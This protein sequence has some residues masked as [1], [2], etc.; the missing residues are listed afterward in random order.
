MLLLG[1]SAKTYQK[2]E[3]EVFTALL[4][5][6]TPGFVLDTYFATPPTY[7]PFPQTTQILANV[8][9]DLLSVFIFVVGFTYFFKFTI[10]SE[11]KKWTKK[12]F[13][14]WI[15]FCILIVFLPII[16]LSVGSDGEHVCRNCRIMVI[17]QIF[18]LKFVFSFRKH[19]ILIS[20]LFFFI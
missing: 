12:S 16:C 20:F 19:H 18:D 8:L 4:D 5:L 13:E 11:Q 17:F 3:I 15:M 6:P 14:M 1:S 9:P 10:P 7:H 2:S